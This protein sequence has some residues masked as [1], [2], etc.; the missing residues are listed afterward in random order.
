[1]P[2]LYQFYKIILKHFT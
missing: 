1:M 2:F